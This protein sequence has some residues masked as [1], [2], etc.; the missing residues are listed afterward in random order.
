MGACCALPYGQRKE[1]A[2][3]DLRPRG[4]VARIATGEMQPSYAFRP[5]VVKRQS[6]AYGVG[7]GSSVDGPAGLG[8]VTRFVLTAFVFTGGRRT[9]IVIAAASGRSSTY[10]GACEC[11]SAIP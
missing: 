5:A 4:G 9:G 8:F 10:G 1:A 6:S 7:S 11:P 3:R 2:P